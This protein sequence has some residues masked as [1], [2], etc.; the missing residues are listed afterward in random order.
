VGTRRLVWV[1]SSES[2]D[3]VMIL[4]S[5]QRPVTLVLSSDDWKLFCFR[6]RQVLAVADIKA[7]LES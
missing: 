6:R 1:A 3:P 4:V 7:C 2:V 5:E